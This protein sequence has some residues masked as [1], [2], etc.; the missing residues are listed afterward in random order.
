MTDVPPPTERLSYR[1]WR[2]SDA[3]AMLDMY[4]RPDVYR[5]LGAPPTPMRDVAEARA[6]IVDRNA[7]AAGCAGVWAVVRR[8]DPADR[9]VGAALFVPL[10]RSDG[11]PSTVH[12]IGWHLHPDVWGSGYATEAGRAMIARARAAGLDGVHAVVYAENDR[13]R[14]V[15]RRLGMTELGATVEWYGVELIDHYLDLGSLP[16]SAGEP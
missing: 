5:F 1:A 6:K 9:P 3:A 13:S 10:P 15:C 7:R 8:D 16:P 4:S 11:G 14:A 12:E 2:E